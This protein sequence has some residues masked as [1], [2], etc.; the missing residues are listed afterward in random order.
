MGGSPVGLEGAP[1]SLQR[2]QQE[3]G[4]GRLVDG[5]WEEPRGTGATPGGRGEEGTPVRTAA[6][7]SLGQACC[8]ASSPGKLG[9]QCQALGWAL[10][11]VSLLRSGLSLILV[12]G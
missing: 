2:D 3:Q 4:G 8:Q 1:C 12:R 9:E 11:N 6:H 7:L 5:I 10:K